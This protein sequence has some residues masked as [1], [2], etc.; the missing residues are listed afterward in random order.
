MV[1]FK[2]SFFLDLRHLGRN[3]LYNSYMKGYEFVLLIVERNF[4]IFNVE[5]YIT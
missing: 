5:F 4:I 3:K 2:I 1:I